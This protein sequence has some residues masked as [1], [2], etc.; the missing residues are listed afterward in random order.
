VIQFDKRHIALVLDLSR[1][2]F[3]VRYLGSFFG[4]YWNVIHPLVM[5]LIYTLIFSQVMGARLG[6]TAEPWAYSL[7]LCSGLLLWNLFCETI[8]RCTTILLENAA[9]MRKVS[10]PP[11]NMFLVSF[12]SSWLNYFISFAIFSIFMIVVGTFS[13]LHA[14]A[15]LCV[16]LCMSLFA[17]GLGATVGCL[18]VFMRDFQQFTAIILQVWFWFT[19]VVYLQDHLPKL[20]IKLLWFNPAY[21]FIDS[22]HEL[23]FYQRIPSLTHLALMVSWSLLALGIASFVYKK[24]ISAIRDE[25]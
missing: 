19:P 12:V 22:A 4:T 17:A 16:V 11:W 9:F 25:L 3:K 13:L 1:R 24:T 23:L 15:Y 18:N 21:P 14:A 6:T 8:N 20:A 2:D 7:Y 10:F 5:I